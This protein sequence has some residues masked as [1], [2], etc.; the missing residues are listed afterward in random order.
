MWGLG[1]RNSTPQLQ[2]DRLLL[3]AS[4]DDVGI[5]VLLQRVPAPFPKGPMCL[6]RGHLLNP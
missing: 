6:Y 3:K 2:I 5:V 4:L 1:L